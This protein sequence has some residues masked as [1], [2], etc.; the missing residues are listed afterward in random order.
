MS[1]HEMIRHLPVR[2]TFVCAHCGS[3]EGYNRDRQGLL[4]QYIFP[5][6]FIQPMRCCDCGDR[7][8]W[9]P[10]GL[11]RRVTSGTGRTVLASRAG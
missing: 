9:L 1:I 7:S 10:V 11:L 4:E 6:L 3:R 8:H 2:P 5:L